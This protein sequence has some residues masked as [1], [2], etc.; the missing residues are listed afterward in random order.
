MY[1]HRRMRP[2]S[3]LATINP[4]EIVIHSVAQPIGHAFKVGD[5][6]LL[7]YALFKR[8]DRLL[9]LGN[10]LSKRFA[11]GKSR[12]HSLKLLE[13]FLKLTYARIQHSDFRRQYRRRRRLCRA[14]LCFEPS[15]LRC[16]ILLHSR[17]SGDVVSDLAQQFSS[18]LLLSLHVFEFKRYTRRSVARS[19][20]WPFAYVTL[21]C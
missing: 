19:R 17:V 21:A 5:L 13:S 6:Y 16:Y 15:N 11:F 8:H 9:N 3:G 18:L 2:R 7:T 1:S 12:A 10:A 14:N 4:V 20:L